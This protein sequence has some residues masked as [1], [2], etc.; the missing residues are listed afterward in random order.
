M[1]CLTTAFFSLE[2]LNN[3]FTYLLQTNCLA[4]DLLPSKHHVMSEADARA[5]C[6][7]AEV[8]L[9]VFDMAGTTVDDLVD[10]EPLVIAA[11]RATLKAH[12]GTEVDFAK[13]NEVR[14]YEKKEALKLLM[15]LTRGVKTE[16]I[17]TSEVNLVY[18]IFEA[19]LEKLSCRIN[20]EVGGTAACFQELKRRGI[21]ICVGSGFP[22][23]VVRSIVQNMSWSVDGA[24]S[25]AALGAGR[26]DPIMIHAAMKTCGVEDP[27]RVVKVGD[28][29]VDVEEGKNAGCWTVSVLSGTQPREKLETAGPD[30]IIQSVA[31]FASLLST[32]S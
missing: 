19:E 2:F 24:F 3:T 26:P 20:S 6:L 31:D 18:K 22:E 11:F 23:H 5:L 16:D 32:V 27:K 13:A 15:S 21:K 30:F 9:V 10:G 29:K 12:D 17:D 25:S 4:G 28:T 1:E 7:P 14:G 8:E